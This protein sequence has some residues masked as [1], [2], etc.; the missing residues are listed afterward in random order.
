MIYPLF[1]L[2]IAFAIFAREFISHGENAPEQDRPAF[3]QLKLTRHGLRNEEAIAALGNDLPSVAAH[4]HKSLDELRSLF[5]RD[6]DARL[7]KDE[8]IM[9]VCDGLVAPVV[10]SQTNVSDIPVS[11]LQPLGQTFLLHSKT[12]STKVIFLDFDGHTLSGNQWTASYNGGSNIVAPP[13]DIDGNPA[14]FG[15]SE[16]IAIQQIWLRVAEDYAPYDVENG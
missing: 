8:R 13:W 1:T 15:D 5:W 12:G 10:S 4:Y 11:A 3:P 6:K 9:F 14:V 7:D 2:L 16:R